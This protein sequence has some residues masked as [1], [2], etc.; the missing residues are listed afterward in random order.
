MIKRGV[1]L[2][3]FCGAPSRGCYL[4]DHLEIGRAYWN[5]QDPL[6]AIV[7]PEGTKLIIEIDAKGNA[8]M[9]RGEDE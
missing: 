7:V 9:F 4:L 6:S 1:L 2:R 5:A 3:L 8:V